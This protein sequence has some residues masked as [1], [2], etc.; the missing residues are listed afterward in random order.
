[1]RW[2]ADT[3]IRLR[4]YRFGR[5]SFYGLRFLVMVGEKAPDRYRALQFWEKSLE[6]HGVY[7][8]ILDLSGEKGTLLTLS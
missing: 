8:R 5:F 3:T 7:H 6:A 1:M 4:D 2:D